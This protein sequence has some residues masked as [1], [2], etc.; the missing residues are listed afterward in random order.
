MSRPNA[1]VSVNWTNG[2]NNEYVLEQVTNKMVQS[3][4]KHLDSLNSVTSYTIYREDG[5]VIVSTVQ[6]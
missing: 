2:F 1:K 5:S 3:E 4:V 6:S